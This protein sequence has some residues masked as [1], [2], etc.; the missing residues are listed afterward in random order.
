MLPSSLPSWLQHA[1][2]KLLL[3]PPWQGGNWLH[4]TMA[5]LLNQE[6]PSPCPCPCPEAVSGLFCTYHCPSRANRIR[7]KHNK[8]LK[9]WMS[10]CPILCWTLSSQKSCIEFGAS[11][12]QQSC[13]PLGLI[14]SLKYQGRKSGPGRGHLNLS[15]ASQNKMRQ[16][17]NSCKILSRV[18]SF[19]KHT[20]NTWHQPH[21]HRQTHTWSVSSF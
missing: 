2:L 7:D 8:S 1:C 10:Y 18:S 20:I 9:F 13:A 17:L 3:Q 4:V 19:S 16:Q 5:L 21:P 6:A 14:S 11:K 12:G 15:S